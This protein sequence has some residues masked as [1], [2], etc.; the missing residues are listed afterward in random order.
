MPILLSVYVTL[1]WW[2][3]NRTVYANKITIGTWNALVLQKFTVA[4]LLGWLLIPI[5]LI[6]VLLG[7]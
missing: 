7:R 1:G 6:K 4:F 2:A 5:A 3:A